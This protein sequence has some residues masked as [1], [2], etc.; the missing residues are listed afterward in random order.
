[1]EGAT[2]HELEHLDDL[3]MAAGFGDAEHRGP[4]WYSMTSHESETS[5]KADSSEATR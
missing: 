1:M 2:P 4:A 5:H 3:K